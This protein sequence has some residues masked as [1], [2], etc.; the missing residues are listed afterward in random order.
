[1][2][3]WWSTNEEVGPHQI[4][5]LWHL[6]FE[7]ASVQNCEKHMPLFK[8]P[9]V[10]YFH[11]SILNRLRQ[12]CRQF[13]SILI[14]FPLILHSCDRFVKTKKLI[15]VDSTSD[16]NQILSVFPLIFCFH[17]RIQSRILDCIESYLFLRWKDEHYGCMSLKIF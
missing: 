13:L 8:P 14:Q 2:K 10:R 3:K 16:F 12:Q 15:P 9:R 11:Y 5:N 7:L 17:F 4:S 6:D 1:M